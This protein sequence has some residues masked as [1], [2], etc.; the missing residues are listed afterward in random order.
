MG[1]DKDTT[2]GGRISAERLQA[3]IAA[4]GADPKRWPEADRTLALDAMQREGAAPEIAARLAE[5]QALDRLLDSA[6]APSMSDAFAARLIAA[7]P[8]AEVPSAAHD[9]S[10]AST[11]KPDRRSIVGVLVA[12]M[13]PARLVP[14]AALGVAAVL[15]VVAGAG[16]AFVVEP[17]SPEAELA[18]LASEAPGY[19]WTYEETS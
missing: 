16:G 18:A 19:E 7:A 5:E 4:Y 12:F 2:F 11:A 13:R 17:L 15:G 8:V 1:E 9:I 14:A 3:L 10:W 6:P